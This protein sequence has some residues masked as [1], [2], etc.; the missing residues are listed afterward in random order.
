MNLST[1]LGLRNAALSL[2]YQTVHSYFKNMYCIELYP[3][4][5]IQ[6]RVFDWSSYGRNY[7]N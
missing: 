6:C 7:E 1:F 2:G 4:S 5:G 3:E